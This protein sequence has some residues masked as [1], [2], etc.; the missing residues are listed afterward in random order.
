MRVSTV[1]HAYDDLSSVLLEA[2][3][4]VAVTHNHPEGIKRTWCDGSAY[5]LNAR[6]YDIRMT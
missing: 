3:R 1:A 4:S 2:K 6:F 5:D